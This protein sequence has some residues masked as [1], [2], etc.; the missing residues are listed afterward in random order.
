[1]SDSS[2]NDSLF[3]GED[4]YGDASLSHLGIIRRSGRYP[5]G[6]G[7]NPFQRSKLF[8]AYYEQM[9][10][11]GMTDT[12]IA[13]AITEYINENRGP[14]D[15]FI[16]FTT[17][18]LR[19]ATAVSTEQIFA[20]NRAM[21]RRLKE[22]KDLSNVKIGEIMGGVNE[23]TVR[24]WL[25][26]GDKVKE[27]SL[28]AVTEKLKQEVAEKGFLEVGKGTEL[29]MGITDSKLR[30]ALAML[31]DEG[32]NLHHMDQSQLGTDKQTKLRILTTED[33]TWRDAYDAKQAGDVYNIATFTDDGGLSFKTA[34]KPTSV[35]L[36][37]IDVRY[38]DD[39]GAQMDGVIELRRGVADLDLGSKRY[40]QVRIA[41]DD[42]HYL[43]GMAMYADDLPP[44]VDIRFNTNKSK[45]DA[46][47][48]V[49]AMKP[50]KRD[51]DGE[52]DSV[53]PFGATT[54]PKMYVDKNGK[55][56]QS[57]LNIVNEEGSWDAWSKSLSS[58]ML[59]K[60][61]ISLAS[62]QLRETQR[63]R[64]EEFDEI[65]S[66]TNPVVRQKLLHEFAESADAAAVHLKAA[67][68]P[69]QSS[70]VILPI[71]SMRPNEI[72]APNFENGDKVALVRYPH[73]GTFEIPS[74]VVNNKNTKAKRI[75]GGAIDAVG[76]HHSVAEQLSGA[77][78]DG[79]SVL[80]IL[81]NDG[82]VRSRPPL[83]KLENFDPKVA[84]P[85][86]PGMK[87]MTKKNTQSEMGKISNLITDMTL[88]GAPD[89]DLARAVRHSMVVIDAEKHKLDYKLSEK[90]NGIAKLKETYQGGPR[91]GASTIISQ[92]SATKRVDKIQPRPAKDGGPIDPETGKK[93]FVPAPD[94]EYVKKS[95][96]IDRRTG[97]EVEVSETKTRQTKGTRME[98]TD[99][100]RTLMS[101]NPTPMEELYASHA[102]TM[103]SMANEARR[104]AVNTDLPRQDKNARK[105]YAKEVESLEAKLKVAQRNAPLERRA[106]IL[107]GAMA[108]ARIDS[109]PHYDKDDIK[110]IKYQSLEEARRATGA[111]KVKIGAPD[112]K[113]RPT[114]TPR[115]W[116]AVQAGAFS[117]SRLKEILANADMDVVKDLAKPKPRTSLTSGQLARAKMMQA[118]GKSVAEIARQL[119]IPRSTLS[120]NLE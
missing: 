24:G 115:E 109:N 46:P 31:Q 12:Q 56:K 51:A 10:L 5:W 8:K 117:P 83:K 110:K 45:A 9:K 116:E 59:S 49:D 23:S 22:D 42:T 27:N 60:Q 29:Y 112:A 76:I 20:E 87:R 94:R 28:R 16:K 120:D 97:E 38:A 26:A 19:A 33:K 17:S 80:V 37:R 92:A 15:R 104:V 68:L 101:K 103:K 41:V 1:M 39:G 2:E 18:D 6:S 3:T 32:Y 63:K 21:A 44:G 70:H 77:D 98:F 50:L 74:L 99:D 57:P 71:N 90:Q 91:S 62:Q 105:V 11:D 100:A 93:V 14:N 35:D 84:Y 66:L 75:L 54:K 95:V 89:D 64:K 102:N 79:D 86:S 108:K 4:I 106:Q 48:K 118:S 30:A 43:K 47:N 13:H 69:R 36:K 73:G 61:P 52:I 113:G 114:I 107:G 65:M 85:E 58:Q 7:K 34:S 111:A 88:K 78:F 96:K 53:S 72:Y 55:E 119:G 67:A 82:K 40:A 25:A 81:N